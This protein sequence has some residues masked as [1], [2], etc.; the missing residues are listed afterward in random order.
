MGRPRLDGE[1]MK[2]VWKISMLLAM[3]MLAGG[4]LAQSSN[5]VSNSSP[6]SADKPATRN[7]G[8]RNQATSDYVIGAD[9]VLHISVWKEPDLSET[10]PVRPD[11]KIS[12]PL[13]G[14]VEAAGMTPTDLGNSITE[15]LKKCSRLIKFEMKSL[16]TPI[17]DDRNN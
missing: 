7:M 14:D 11:G 8:G 3:L 1:R 13:L 10:L 15:K 17:Q 16:K 2:N 6:G 4:L 12:M 9:D 5:A